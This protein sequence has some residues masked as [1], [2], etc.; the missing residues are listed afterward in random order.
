MKII[1]KNKLYDLSNIEEFVH[2]M[3]GEGWY[4]ISSVHTEQGETR[5]FEDK[6][7][8]QFKILYKKNIHNVYVPKEILLIA[9]H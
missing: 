3:Y 7:H 5:T 4:H 6:Q 2:K 9:I 1:L 8:N